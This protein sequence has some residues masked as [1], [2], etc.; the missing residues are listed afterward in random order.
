[1]DINELVN[2]L[3]PAAQQEVRAVMAE[4]ANEALRAELAELRAS[5]TEPE[6]EENTE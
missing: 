2:R 3:S 4:F 5:M 1:M 6:P